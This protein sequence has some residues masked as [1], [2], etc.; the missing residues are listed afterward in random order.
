M[1]AVTTLTVGAVITVVLLSQGD[2]A[3]T[4]FLFLGLAFVLALLYALPPLRLIYSGYGELVLAIL[5]TNLFP[6]LAYVLQAG[7]LHRLLAMMTFP[8]TL[9]FLA[10]MLALSLQSYLFDM[11]FHRQTMM[12]RL[13]WQRG[14][15]LHN[16]LIASAYI[17]L[18]FSVIASLPF[19]LGFPAFLSL[20]V[21]I[22]QIRQ[23]NGIAGGSKPRWRL[24]SITAIASVGLAAYF[25]NLALW[26][27]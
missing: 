19:R 26:T 14:I 16:I 1:V 9:L 21:S 5:M 17:L 7:D 2:L 23:I 25:M 18:A 6:A 24:L 10:A 11:K 13:G 22:Y 27:D 15:G 4:A 12:Q 8:L 20:P 3:P